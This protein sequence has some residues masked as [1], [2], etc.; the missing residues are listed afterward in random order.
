MSFVV[1]AI[2]LFIGLRLSERKVSSGSRLASIQLAL[3]WGGLGADLALGAIELACALAGILTFSL[4][5]TLYLVTIIVVV[6]SL[7]G[8]TGFLTYVY[9]GRYHLLEVGGIYIAFYLAFLYWFFSEAPNAIA[10]EAGSA[11][12]KYG[13]SGNLALELVLVLLLLVPEILAAVLYLSLLRRT[14]DSAQRYRITLVGG[15]ILL[16]FAIDVVIPGTTIP[17]LIARTILLAIPALMSLAAYYPPAWARRRYGATAIET[18]GTDA[19]E[20]VAGA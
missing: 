4:A 19:V 15:G 10:I 20:G 2:Y 16:F 7:W 8:V 12:W 14:R 9:T 18:E 13:N 3:W 11:V 17:W 5:M 6:S 1:G